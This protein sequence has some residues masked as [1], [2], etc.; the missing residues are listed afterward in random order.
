[1]AQRAFCSFDYDD[2]TRL[3]VLLFG[4]AKLPESAVFITAW[5]SKEP[6]ADWKN[7]VRQRTRANGAVNVLF[8]RNI[9]TA[10]G[11]TVEMAI[12]QQRCNPYFM[13]AAIKQ[14]SNMPV[15]AR[16]EDKLYNWT[17]ACL[18]AIVGGVR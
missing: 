8:G 1:M 11:L 4:Q 17:W 18:K 15:T 12:T 14:G 10:T 9:G 6:T 2:V 13:L 16:P 5:S 3:K 7:R